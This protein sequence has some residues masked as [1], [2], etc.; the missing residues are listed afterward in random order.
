MRDSMAPPSASCKPTQEGVSPTMKLLE[1]D[2]DALAEELIAMAQAARRAANEGDAGASL[3]MLSHVRDAV[4]E[5]SGSRLALLEVAEA[6]LR[7][8]ARSDMGTREVALS[9]FFARHPEEAH[10]LVGSMLR[11]E[12][13]S[14]RRL[15]S[16]SPEVRETIDG[17]VRQG[18]FR[19]REARM[20]LA[21][22]LRPLAQDLHEPVA[23]RMWRAVEA[24]RSKLAGGR[25]TTREAASVLAAS[26]GVS[27]EQALWHLA[28]APLAP[29]PIR[30]Q[31]A[32]RRRSFGEIGAA[33]VRTDLSD[34]LAALTASSGDDLGADLL[35]ARTS[36]RS[37]SAAFFH[38]PPADRT[39]RPRP[40]L[41]R[42]PTRVFQKRTLARGRRR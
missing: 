42:E 29:E 15:V 10:H 32:R 36:Q 12:A 41:K 40:I 21:P 5:A 30:E 7:A 37:Q 6:F 11:A 1:L 13:V 39:S 22:A 24:A 38:E 31:Q 17:L 27:E 33:P 35:T 3:D 19:E 25:L 34:L 28:H 8:L 23:F 18:V 9:V 2:D 26:L 16:L 20:E 4:A 14:I